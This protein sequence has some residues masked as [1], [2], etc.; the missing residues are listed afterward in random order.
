[1][2]VT[3]LRSY[4]FGKRPNSTGFI[5]AP[6][7]L[8]YRNLICEADVVHIQGYR[9]FMFVGAALLSLLYRTPYLVQAR[10]SLPSQLGRFRL[11]LV[12]DKSIGPALLK[13][14]AYAVA[15]SDAESEVY[16]KR[17]VSQSR[18]VKVLNPLDPALC[19]D[20]PERDAFRKK[21]GIGPDEKMILFLS[22]VHEKKG[23]DLLIRAMAVLKDPSARLC[24]VG[25]DGGFLD[26]ARRMI[27]EFGIERQVLIVGP[28]YGTAKYEAYRSA[29]VYVLP[30]RGVEG[31]PT[32][33]LE[34]LYTGTPL[35]VTNTTEIARLIDGR[36]GIAIDYDVEQLRN[37]LQSILGDEGLA[38]SFG[39]QAAAILSDHFDMSAALDRF[40]SLYESAVV[41]S[42]KRSQH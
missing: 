28:L 42:G 24:V 11:K 34:A 38:A 30:T 37:A 40:E 8:K 12:F 13:H 4:W 23:L 31:L 16:L 14:A 29:D 15:L 10:G 7:M 26:T 36:A 32:T 27:R 17:G 5:L 9:E 39:N 18:L 41:H 1:L 35:I 22:R 6:D 19:P 21:Y 3:Y 25:P 33:I 20:L 2:P